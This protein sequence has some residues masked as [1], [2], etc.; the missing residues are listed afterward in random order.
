MKVTGETMLFKNDFGFSTTISNK[1]Q[2]GTYDNMSIVVQFKKDDKD[3]QNIPTKTK[4]NILNGFLTFY[5]STSGEK[6][7]K[8]AVLEYEVVGAKKETSG[9]QDPFAKSEDCIG[10]NTVVSY[11]GL[12]D[13][14][15]LPF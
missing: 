1:K 3:A 15:D 4:I 14:D 6:K 11:D 10:M 7:L 13:D 5:Y 12:G 2:D 9:Y 8:L